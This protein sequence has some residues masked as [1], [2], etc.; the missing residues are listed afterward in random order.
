MARRNARNHLRTVRFSRAEAEQIDAYLERN[1]IFDSFSSLARV[2]ALDFVGHARKLRLEP[3]AGA[4][5][6]PKRPRFL[7]DYDL[8]D[9]AVRE[10]LARPG[11]PDE[12]RFLME[13]ILTEGRF[14]EVFEY[15]TLGVLVRHFHALELPEAKKRH[16][17]YALSRWSDNG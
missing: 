14:E 8:S 12:K 5:L 16:W 15:L 1:A 9:A 7:W 11:L 4:D 6:P 13:R 2:A 17:G 10:I 3:V